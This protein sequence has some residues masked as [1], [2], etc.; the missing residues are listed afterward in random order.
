MDDRLPISVLLL[1]RDE[2][3]DLEELV[4]ALGFA[5]E[6]LVVWD[7]RGD[8]ATRDTAARLGARVEERAFDGFGPQ[9]AWAL[10]HCT[11]PWV[12]WLDADERL[13]ASAVA[14]IR[15]AVRA[16][17]GVTHHRLRRATWFLGRRIRWCGWRGETVVRLFRRGRARFDDA[18]VH[19]TVAVEGPGP[20]TLAGVIEHHSYRTFADCV[21]KCVRY[22]RAGAERAWRRGRRAGPLD[23]LFRP[24]L[25]FARQ[26]VLQLGFLDGAHGLVLCAF[27][28]AQVL[29][30]YAEL[31]QRTRDAK[32]P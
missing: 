26:Y 2:T 18:E 28:S 25:R 6:V 10:G 23:V 19:E 7:P 24:P 14:A 11:Q 17:G 5:R 22:A 3:R 27:A 12:L 21:G 32:R 16:D 4:P 20:G 9:R 15:D 8:R 1:A 30:K 31:W 29:F 13:D